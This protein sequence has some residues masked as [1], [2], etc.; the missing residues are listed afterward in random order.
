M[1]ESQRE[2]HLKTFL[3]SAELA[4]GQ[5][6]YSSIQDYS[7]NFPT[8]FSYANLSSTDE[9]VSDVDTGETETEDI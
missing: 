8:Q 1:W 6:N 5:H 7:H 2:T 3:G 4:N 9:D